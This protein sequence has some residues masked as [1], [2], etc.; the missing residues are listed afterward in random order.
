MSLYTWNNLSSVEN[1]TEKLISDLK[2]AQKQPKEM[3]DFS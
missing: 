2:R 1:D 3:F